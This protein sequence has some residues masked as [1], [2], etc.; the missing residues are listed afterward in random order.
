MKRAVICAWCGKTALLES[1]HINRSRSQGLYL[2]CG[3]ECSGLGRRKGKSKTQKI[4]EKAV[5]DREYRATHRDL[6]KAK[7]ASY[8]RATYDPEA[9]RV[10]RKA[11]MPY[12]V[13]YCRQPECRAK[14]QI[15]DLKRRG[16]TFGE[17]ADSYMLLSEIEREI[18]DRASRY[19]V[20]SA[21]GTL[22]KSLQR[23]R[24]Y[25]TFSN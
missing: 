21:N 9:A 12:L 16:R 15:Y 1:S 4:A 22:N 18:A 6:L 7:K 8:F 25:E 13:A 17:F 20:Y 2:Y 11:R 3:R 10:Q 24:H 5:Y 14:K 23:K 19:E